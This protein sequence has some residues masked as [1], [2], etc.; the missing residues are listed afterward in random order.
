MGQADGTGKPLI[1]QRAERQARSIAAA[2]DGRG[3]PGPVGSEVSQ[4]LELAMRPRSGMDDHH[5][6]YLHPG[7]SALILLHDVEDLPPESIPLA[8]LH[9][10]E[11]EGL[12]PEASDVLQVFGAEMVQHVT[13]LPLP[14][15]EALTERLVLLSRAQLLAALVERLDHLRH[16]HMRP[17]LEERWSS[18]WEEVR[19]VWLPVAQRTDARL[20]RRF[21]HWERTFAKRLRRRDRT[22]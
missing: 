18:A 6:A 21:A 13:D 16:F 2:L 1:S 7:R 15:D 9:E 17:E 8:V 4:A 22:G 20:T 19:G 11:D 5:P 12:R 10:S 14:G 3:V